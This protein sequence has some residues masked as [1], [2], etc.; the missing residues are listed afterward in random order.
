MRM[1]EGQEDIRGDGRGGNRQV[2]VVCFS[3]RSL[4]SQL[5]FGDVAQGG[6]RSALMFRPGGGATILTRIINSCVTILT[7]RPKVG[8]T[9]MTMDPEG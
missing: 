1:V 2:V 4:C 9:V 3:R 8:A 6:S 7:S 5:P